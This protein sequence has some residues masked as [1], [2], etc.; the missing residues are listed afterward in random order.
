M[1]PAV[2]RMH[3]TARDTSLLKPSLIPSFLRGFCVFRGIIF[4]EENA[5]AIQSLEAP[6]KII[7]SPAKSLPKGGD[8]I[9]LASAD[10]STV[11]RG[12]SVK[13]YPTIFRNHPLTARPRIRQK[14]PNLASKDREPQN[15]LSFTYL[16]YQQLALALPFKIY[17]C[18]I[19][20]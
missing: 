1:V 3:E 9:S 17:S 2:S 6:D 19:C 16:S 20:S 5:H 18:I 15:S 8:P 14:L 11:F 10:G 12:F 7:S 4:A 13:K